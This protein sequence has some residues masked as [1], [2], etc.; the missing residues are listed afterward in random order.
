MPKILS[1]GDLH[2]N[3]DSRFDECQRVLQ[4]VVDVAIKERPDVCVIPGDVY[5][6]LSTIEERAAV[7]DFVQ[8]MAETCPGPGREGQ[9]R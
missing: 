2:F 7:A 4:F 8:G 9:P 1:T 3:E 5:H 6:S